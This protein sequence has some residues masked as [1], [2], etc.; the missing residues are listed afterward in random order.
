MNMRGGAY[1]S[2][3]IPLPWCEGGVVK[4]IKQNPHTRCA[5]GLYCPENGHMPS[6][7]IFPSSFHPCPLLL[8]HS[9]TLG[10]TAHS[11]A[12]WSYVPWCIVGSRLPS[13]SS[14]PPTVILVLPVELNSSIV[15]VWFCIV[16]HYRAIMVIVLPCCAGL[17]CRYLLLS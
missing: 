16:Y 15:I 5:R 12:M 9:T 3:L 4:L 13:P 10:A 1:T 7:A 2:K 6:P 11:S 17:G 14:C 8:A